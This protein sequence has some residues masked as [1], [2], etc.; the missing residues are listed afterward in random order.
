SRLLAG[1][2][3]MEGVEVYGPTDLEDRGGVIS[4]NVGGLMPHEVAHV[5]DQA[6]N[7]MVRSGHH[8]CI[9]LM[10]HL[11]L[12]YG[13]VRASLYLYNTIEEVDRLLGVVEQIAGMAQRQYRR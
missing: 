4:F 3:E 6:S 7:I 5:L 13:T 10:R 1:L 11:G 9:P 12:K 2:R 8:C